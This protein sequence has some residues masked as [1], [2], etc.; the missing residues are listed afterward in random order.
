M[1]TLVIG[2]GQVGSALYEVIKPH[3][4]TYIKDIEAL[5]LDGVEVLQICYPEHET[6]KQTTLDYIKQYNPSLV[7]INSSISVGTTR[8]IGQDI[9]YSP[10]RG[11]HPKLASDMK[12]Y[13]KFVFCEDVE[14]NKRATDYFESCGL[15]V[16]SFPDTFAGE[17]LKLISNVH[18]GVEIAWRQE[19]ERLLKNLKIDPY[20]Y[21]EWEDTYSKGYIESQDFNLIR[22]SMSPAPIGGHC[23]LPCTEILASQYPSKILDFIIESN[24]QTKG[25]TNGTIRN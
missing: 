7:I 19:V 15:N 8:K 11:R 12:I 13:S 6:F 21:E 25:D 23:I 24:N 10:V 1:K 20:I 18:M 22:P 14:A 2:K 4:E 9:V 16:Q 3:H 17:I 5:E